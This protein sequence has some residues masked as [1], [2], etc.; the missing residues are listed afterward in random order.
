MWISYKLPFSTK[1]FMI[2]IF[3]GYY[4][5][6]KSVEKL[7]ECY[8]LKLSWLTWFK[9]KNVYNSKSDTLAKK[10][11]LSTLAYNIEFYQNLLKHDTIV[12]IYS[13]HELLDLRKKGQ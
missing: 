10:K 4:N 12:K 7:F 8:N 1:K 13:F 2:N 11:L 6:S 3:V 5:L 9:K